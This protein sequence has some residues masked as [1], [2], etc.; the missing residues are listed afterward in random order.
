M[1]SLFRGSGDD[2]REEVGCVCLVLAF[3]STRLDQRVCRMTCNWGFPIVEGISSFQGFVVFAKGTYCHEH[4]HQLCKY[5]Q[6]VV[7]VVTGQIGKRVVERWYCELKTDIVVVCVGYCPCDC[8]SQRRPCESLSDQWIV[9]V[10]V[11]QY[12]GLQCDCLSVCYLCQRC[13]L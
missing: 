10:V 6:G 3:E 8:E 2:E 9:V 12:P 7:G 1:I 11:G 5:L 4:Q 13:G